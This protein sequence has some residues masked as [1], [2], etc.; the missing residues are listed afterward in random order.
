MKPEKPPAPKKEKRPEPDEPD[1]PGELGLTINLDECYDEFAERAKVL[2]FLR[3]EKPSR[4][5]F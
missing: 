5:P 3:P 1:E 4:A 2:P